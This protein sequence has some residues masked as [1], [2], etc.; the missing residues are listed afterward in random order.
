MAVLSLGV[1]L[2]SSPAADIARTLPNELAEMEYKLRAVVQPIK[3]VQKA[4]EEVE[5][6]AAKVT[7]GSDDDEDP[8]A[9]AASGRPESKRTE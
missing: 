1:Y 3:K 6:A 9:A 7:G 2:V 5:K 8:R 4:A